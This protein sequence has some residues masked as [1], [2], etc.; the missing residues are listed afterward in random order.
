M[1]LIR[2][3]ALHARKRLLRVATSYTSEV[4]MFIHYWCKSIVPNVSRLFFCYCLS[5]NKLHLLANNLN[6]NPGKTM[7]E[8]NYGTHFRFYT[9][10]VHRSKANPHCTEPLI[11]FSCFQSNALRNSKCMRSSTAYLGL[12][13]L[14]YVFMYDESLWWNR[15]FSILAS[16]KLSKH[17]YLSGTNR[18]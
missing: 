1:C 5:W 14:I 16:V 4:V 3:T 18:N 15:Y 9:Y 8:I 6:L 12:Q 10:I 11:T 13:Y 2:W 17:I 7:S